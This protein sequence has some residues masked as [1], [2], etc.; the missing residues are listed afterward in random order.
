MRDNYSTLIC[1][2]KGPNKEVL[3]VTFNNEKMMNAMT[4]A[5]QREMLDALEKAKY[6]N[7]IRC[8]ILTGSGE[9]AFSAGGDINY[10]LSL[11]KVSFYDFMYERGNRI[12]HAITY[13]EK[14]VIAAVNGFCFGGGLEI[15]LCCDFI[16]ASKN[17]RFGLTEITIGLLPG[18]GGTVRLPRTISVNR[19]KEMI[20]KGERITAEEAYRVGLVNKIF[21]TVSDLHKGVEAC[22]ND[23]IT[24]PPLAVRAAKNII[25]N[26]I[27]CDSMEAALAIERQGVSWLASSEDMLEGV[28]AFQEKRS[29]VFKGK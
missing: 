22:A 17:A 15:S 14:P 28:T 2:R 24:K 27:T 11:D 3:W 18:W 7:G 29:P 13:M 19:A 21:D 12:Q 26:S 1:E 9:K 23:I 6:D 4:E 8:V 25:N 16:Y 10:F 20:Y 5:M